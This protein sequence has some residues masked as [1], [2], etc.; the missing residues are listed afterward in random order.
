[1]AEELAGV[2]FKA[3]IIYGYGGAEFSGY[4]NIEVKGSWL[5]R[6]RRLGA[7]PEFKRGYLS[8]DSQ[9][10]FTKSSGSTGREKMIS[11]TWA[12]LHKAV[13]DSLLHT[14]HKPWVSPCLVSLGFS[15]LWGYRQI[16]TILW[17]G[18]TL[19]LGNVDIATARKFKALGVRHIAASIAQLN[20][21]VKIARDNPGS[22]STLEIVTT[23]GARLSPALAQVVRTDL[24][25]EIYIN[26][27]SSETGLI[28][29][30]NADILLKYPDAVGVVLKTAT[31]EIVDEGGHVL[32]PGQTGSIRVRTGAMSGSDKA[33]GFLQG[34]FYTGDSGA[35][36]GDGTLCVFG[37]NDGVINIDGVKLRLEDGEQA[38][39]EYPGIE[40]VALFIVKD[41]LEISK[42][43]CAYVRGKGFDSEVFLQ[44]VKKIPKITNVAEIGEIPR[45][46][47]GKILRHVLA[48]K[49][50]ENNKLAI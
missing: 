2:R 40:D 18:G 19:V 24:C 43:C 6:G 12:K 42:L 48:S 20:I 28:A 3:L 9:A 41:K 32:P 17:T 38:L 5:A 30:G 4:Q 22:L 31:V 27:G 46:G 39:S 26:Y 16:L 33:E 10:I 25:K 1:V 15:S 34:W 50:L 36:L 14:S 47:N 7:I 44:H 45:G 11:S 8:I 21:W 37:R 13:V 29:A 49:F 35:L 23:G